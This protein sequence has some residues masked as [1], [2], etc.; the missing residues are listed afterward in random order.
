VTRKIAKKDLEKKSNAEGNM[1]KTAV[2]T[3]ERHQEKKAAAR[4]VRPDCL[5][6]VGD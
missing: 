5:K 1:T 4:P 6:V 3:I 2:M